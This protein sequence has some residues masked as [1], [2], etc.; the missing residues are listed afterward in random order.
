MKWLFGILGIAAA[1]LVGYIA[2]PSLR[3]DLTGVAPGESA[4]A[5]GTADPDSTVA[6]P[7]PIAATPPPAPAVVPPAAEPDLAAT[8]GTPDPMDN[9]LAQADPDEGL[10][11]FPPIAVQ[12]EPEPDLADATPEPVMEET[13]PTAPP[14]S[15]P[16]SPPAS[17][18][19]VVAVMQAS[20]R[21]G[22]IKEFGEAQVQGWQAGDDEVAD[23]TTYQTGLVAYTAETVFGVRT[24]QAKAFIKDG[25]V[26]RWIWPNSGME[27]K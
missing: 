5:D 1:G 14:T 11:P 6:A 24:I 8:D 27:I 20:I 2:E 21:A 15:P 10:D 23:G 12:P 16:T 19:D 17:P 7:Q 25:K 26:E 13:P 18:V 3:Q 4:P 22:E 9:G